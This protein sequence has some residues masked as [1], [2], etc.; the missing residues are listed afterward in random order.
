MKLAQFYTSWD[1]NPSPA[2]LFSS[3]FVKV[4][5]YLGLQQAQVPDPEA[6]LSAV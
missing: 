3:E 6:V 5:K 4:N 1:D 2:Q